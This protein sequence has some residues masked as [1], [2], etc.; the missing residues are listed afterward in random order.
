ML[1]CPNRVM[2]LDRHKL[3][4]HEP[5]P[6]RSPSFL[7]R[8]RCCLQVFRVSLTG[9]GVSTFQIRVAVPGDETRL[10]SLIQALAAYERLTDSVSGSAELLR[11]HLFADPPKAEVVV[12]ERNGDILGYALFF[13]TYSTFLT[14]PGL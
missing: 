4:K 12:A 7:G 10:F 8:F 11:S 5:A 6:P 1:V 14:Q 13:S 9:Q 2:G 3:T